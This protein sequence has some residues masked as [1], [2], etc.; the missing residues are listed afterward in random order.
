MFAENFDEIARLASKEH[1]EGK[2]GG[3]GMSNWIT[4]LKA[5]EVNMSVCDECSKHFASW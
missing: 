2:F 5:Y 4:K 1:S 3:G